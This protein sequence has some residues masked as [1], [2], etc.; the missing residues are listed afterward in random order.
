AVNIGC[1][2]ASTACRPPRVNVVSLIWGG[3]DYGDVSDELIFGKG[4]NF[5][6]A[7]RLAGQRKTPSI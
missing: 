3:R 7:K 2:I 6:S 5:V 4:G 1:H